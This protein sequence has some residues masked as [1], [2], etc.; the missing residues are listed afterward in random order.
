VARMTAVQSRD[1]PDVAEVI[2]AQIAAL[3]GAIVT[4]EPQWRQ[5]RWVAQLP[6]G[7]IAY[8]ADDEEGWNKL[9]REEILLQTVAPRVGFAVPDVV[10]SVE[11]DRVQ[12]RRK[13]PGEGGFWIEELVCGWPG[14]VPAAQRLRCDFPL[15]AAG[16]RL[17]NELGKALADLH[18]ALSPE[19][20]AGM[21]LPRLS[22]LASFGDLD[23]VEQVLVG[24]PALADLRPAVPLLRAWLQALPPDWTLTHGDL[25]AP[26]L[27]V[28]S[29]TGQLTGIY[30]FESAASAH[31]LDDFK[32][33]P[34][35][36]LPFM[37]RLLESYTAH[38]GPSIV[39]ADIWKIHAFSALEHLTRV[40]PGTLRRSRVVEWS[41]AAIQ[42]PGFQ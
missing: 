11:A 24:E 5:W 39:L 15:T 3:T 40:C 23:E 42:L 4:A 7:F 19:E 13:T 29:S 33:L 20:M 35:F 25:Y 37:E 2:A 6:D 26:N 36:G 34:G 9:R 32:Y 1:V 38:G 12:L 16:E 22:P 28:A 27:A 10:L 30:D 31:R 14:H 8:V 21:D 41:R 17:A 18:R